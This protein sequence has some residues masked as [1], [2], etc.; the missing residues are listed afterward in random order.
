MNLPNSCFYKQLQVLLTQVTSVLKRSKPIILTEYKQYRFKQLYVETTK[1]SS[2]ICAQTNKQL[3][4]IRNY[5]F[6]AVRIHNKLPH[7]IHNPTTFSIS[8]IQVHFKSPKPKKRITQT[9]F[10][11]M[12]SWDKVRRVEVAQLY[13]SVLNI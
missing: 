7:Y 13:F 4:F 8:C 6:L 10:K 2:Y 1:C 12:S 11:S 9:I 5:N 3:F